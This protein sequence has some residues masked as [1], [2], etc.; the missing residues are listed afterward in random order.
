MAEILSTSYINSLI[1]DY[2]Y[3]ETDKLITPLTTRKTK[4][5][6]LSSTFGTLS[7]KLSSFKSVLAGLKATEDSSLFGYKSATSSATGFLTASAASNAAAGS[8]DI[9]V[10]QLAKADVAMSKDLTSTDLS[11]L[12]GTHNFVIKTGDGS[13]GEF[14]SNIEVS[15]DGTETNKEAMAKIRD[16]INN[17]KAVVTSDTKTAS[18]SYSGGAASIKIDLNGT[19]TIVSLTGG[20]TYEELIDEAV[21]QINSNVSGVTAEKV[22]DSGNV[23]LKLTVNDSSKYISISSDSGFDIVSDLNIGVTKEKGASGIVNASLFSPLTTSSQLSIT[24]KQTGLDYRITELSDS[25]GTSLDFL[26]LNLGVSRPAFDQDQSPDTPGFLYS[27]I[28]SAGNLLNS[29]ISFNGLSIQRNSNLVSDLVEGVSFSLKSVMQAED[30]NVSVTVN[31]DVSTIRSKVEGFVKSFNEVYTYIRE[32]SKISS[33]QRGLFWGDSNTSAVLNILRS[34]SYSEVTGLPEGDLKYLSQLGITFDPSVGLKISDSSAL[35]KKI[36]ENTSEVEAIFNS[37]NGLANTLYNSL[38]PYTGSGG[39]LSNSISS[40]DQNAKYIDDR[41]TASQKRID[42]SAEI[43][44]N[45]YEQLQA[46]LAALL[47]FQSY[48]NPNSGTY[49]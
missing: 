36:S 11:S 32:N 45:R 8:Y 24:A 38:D 13:T 47:S 41:I 34:V 10:N 43:L 39:Y 5:Q 30:T 3:N 25:V 28:T 9:R 18:G 17:D 29:K 26:G 49:F 1:G 42:K 4:Y 20:G 23:S 27:D 37:E 31:T 33:G 40:F 16:A 19:E 22:S 6:S 15:F 14:V 2:T 21:E 7:T 46:Q 35:E 48:F 44:R 12:S